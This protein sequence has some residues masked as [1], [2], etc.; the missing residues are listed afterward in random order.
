MS[1]WVR[2]ITSTANVDKVPVVPSFLAIGN[3]H[4]SKKK[5]IPSSTSSALAALSKRELEIRRK[6]NQLKKEGKIKKNGDDDGFDKDDDAELQVYAEKI[7]QKLGATKSKMLGFGSSSNDSDDEDDNDDTDSMGTGAPEE[8]GRSEVVVRGEDANYQPR[9]GQL[10]TLPVSADAVATAGVGYQRPTGAEADVTNEN[11]TK[12]DVENE[13]DD[14]DELDEDDLID[15]VAQ[16]M[17]EKRDREYRERQEHLKQEAAERLTALELER[18]QQQEQEGNASKSKQTTSGVGGS[19][20]SEGKTKAEVDMYQPKSGSW[21]AFPRPRDISKAYGGGRRVGPGY[22]DEQKS[23]SSVEET[24]EKLQRY[25]VKVGIDVESEKE[26]AG[27]IE[28]ALKIGSVAMQRGMYATA[29]SALEKVTPYCSTNSKVGGQVFLELAMAYEAVGQTQEAITVYKTLSRSR[30]EQIK[31]N[32]KRLLYGIE[33]IQFMQE[34]VKSSEFSRQ[35]AKRTFIDTTGLDNIASKF[36]DVYE[37]AYV[38]LSRSFYKKL[39][40]NVVRNSR[41]ARQI[42]LRATGPGEVE[43]MKIIQALRSLSRRFADALQDEIEKA[44]PAQEPT[45][46]MDGKPI[47][48]HKDPNDENLSRTMEDFVLMKADQMLENLSGEWRLQL[49][50]DKRGDGVKFFNTTVAWQQVDTDAMTFSSLTPQGFFTI[51]QQGKI[52]FNSKRRVLRRNSVQASGGAGLASLF[53]G[54]RTGAVGAVNIERQ[55]VTVDSSLLVTRGVPSRRRASNDD[56]KDYFAVWRR[57]EPGTY[58]Q[59]KRL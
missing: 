50:A 15:L 18:Q 56:E 7:R 55:V 28:E 5:I 59:E 9:R 40:E 52:I 16:R 3:N 39:T 27:A 21:G 58:S 36:D 22:S 19:W 29:V 41:E 30:I 51:Q 48:K 11:V 14:D 34:N 45:A 24:R 47:M 31:I 38:D 46:V 32:A 20:D 53:S 57:V 26:H 49:I 12:D 42:L 6:I 33:A 44:K 4:H 23:I 17:Q 8:G 1:S 35:R 10:G 37:T 25:R 13:S 54:I 2:P 43:R